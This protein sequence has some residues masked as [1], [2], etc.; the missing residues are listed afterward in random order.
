MACKTNNKEIWPCES[1]SAPEI[2]VSWLSYGD[3]KI[4]D[5]LV[6]EY[7]PMMMVMMMVVIMMMGHAGGFWSR[8]LV[9]CLSRIRF[10]WLSLIVQPRLLADLSQYL[11]R[12]GPRSPI[13]TYLHC[14]GR[15][16]GPRLQAIR[17][18]RVN[19]STSHD[20]SPIMHRIRFDRPLGLI[21]HSQK[22]Q[23][24]PVTWRFHPV[25]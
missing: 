16:I 9:R 4:R 13:S 25:C 22:R 20:S 23:S 2:Q 21:S 11:S 15:F 14:Q 17:S 12:I 3:I 18:Q 24:R 19:S 10:R 1:E 7:T 5:T 6:Y 8:W